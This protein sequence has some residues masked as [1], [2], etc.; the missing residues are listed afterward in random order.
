MQNFWAGSAV[1]AVTKCRV[2]PL[3]N[4]TY[5]ELR[6]GD[7]VRGNVT[8]PP[9]FLRLIEGWLPFVGRGREPGRDNT[10]GFSIEG[11]SGLTF[12]YS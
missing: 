6:P 5:Y 3:A 9:R 12:G 1:G 4:P 7:T 11:L 2:T 8:D 10:R